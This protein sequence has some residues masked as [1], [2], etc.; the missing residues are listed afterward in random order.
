MQIHR[1]A[2]LFSQQCRQTTPIPQINPV[3]LSRTFLFIHT[4][5]VEDP[6]EPL[7]A[8]SRAAQPDLLVRGLF[9]DDVGAGVGEGD[10]EDAGLESVSGYSTIFEAMIRSGIR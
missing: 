5:P 4:L 7:W 2:Q 8:G 1:N 6:V 9:V 3:A 10:G